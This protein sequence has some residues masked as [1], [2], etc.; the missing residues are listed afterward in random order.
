MVRAPLAV[1]LLLAVRL[2]ASEPSGLD[3]A[4]N[5]FYNFDFAGAHI[6]VSDYI[7]HQPGDPLGH[8]VRGAT[9]L[10]SE[11]ARM[12][13]LE[14]E[15]FLDDRRIIDKKGLKPDPEVQTRFFAA[16]NEGQRLAQERL[17]RYPRDRDA[18]FSMT[19]AAGLVADYSSLVQRRHWSGLGYAQQAQRYAVRLLKVDPTAYDAYLTSGVSEYLLGSLPFFMRWFIHF[20]EVEGSKPQAFR[21]LTLVARSGHFFGPFAKVLLSIGY[22]REGKPRESQ[23]LL[24]QLVREFPDNALYRKELARVSDGLRNGTREP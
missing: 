7:A 12:Q 18:L 11:L 20:D 19:I 15:F 14:S 13:L 9:Y 6:I 23:I 1:M 16:V 4:F 22:L 8:M 3:Q 10:F 24:S 5:R 2:Q 21:Y 17:A